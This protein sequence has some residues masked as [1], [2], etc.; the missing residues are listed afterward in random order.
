MFK[1]L[2]VLACSLFLVSCQPADPVEVLFYHPHD[3]ISAQ[4]HCVK[5]YADPD[6]NEYCRQVEAVAVEFQEL[7]N[8]LQFNR[9]EYG[10]ALIRAEMQMVAF[11]QQVQQLHKGDQPNLL[12]DVEKRLHARQ[13]QVRKMLT[14]ISF[15]LSP[16]G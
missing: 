13:Q 9:N 10:D 5:Q 16:T 4:K 7:L 15:A 2:M 12:K 14:V 6:S 1:L 11:Q 8:L 3:L